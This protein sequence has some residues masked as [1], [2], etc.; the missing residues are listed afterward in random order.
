MSDSV[1][2][3]LE[4]ALVIHKRQLAEHGGIEGVRDEGMLSSALARPQHLVAYSNEPPSISQLAAAYTFGIAKNHP[5]LDGNKR[6]AAVV[7]ETFIDLNGHQLDA[8]DQSFCT[9]ILQLA[10]GSL[11]EEELAEWLSEHLVEV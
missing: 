7:C 8:D 6:T 1:W 5:F 9:A 3:S 2:I 11:S 10:E 4:L